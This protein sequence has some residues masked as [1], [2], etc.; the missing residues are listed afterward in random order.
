MKKALLLIISL[1]LG[2]AL[3]QSPSQSVFAYQTV[4][5]DFPQNQGWHAVYYDT[6]AGE[7]ILQYVPDGQSNEDWTKSVIFHAYKN[8]SWTDSAAGLMDRLT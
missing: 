2:Q 6:Q 7:I 8:L 1:F 4:L 3:S 5:V